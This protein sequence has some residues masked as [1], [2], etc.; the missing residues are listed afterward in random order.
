MLAAPRRFG[1]SMATRFHLG[2][3]SVWRLSVAALLVLCIGLPLFVP[4]I[5]WW[6]VGGG[7]DVWS[8]HARIA[9]LA[10]NTL[11]LVGGTLL[12]T[13][14]AGI[15]C[16][17][18]LFRTDL[19]LRELWRFITVLALFVPLPLLASGWQAALGSGGWLPA[20]SWSTPSPGD[21]DEPP[22]GPGW[23]PWAQGLGA[24][25]WVHS[26]AALPW[27][28]LIVGQGLRWV[29][30]ELEEDALL[31]F[32]PWR[33]LWSVT[34]VRARGAVLAA[35]AWGALQTAGEIAVTDMMQVRTFAEEI[36]YQFVLGDSAAL[37]RAVT[38][39]IPLLVV[40]TMVVF[41]LTFRLERGLP[42]L[43]GLGDTDRTGGLRIALGGAR[44]PALAAVLVMVGLLAGLPLI[45]LVWK[46]GL[47]GSP[48]TF[49]ANVAARQVIEVFQT[50]GPLIG[51]SLLVAAGAGIVTA[52]LVLVACWL[53]VESRGLLLLLLGLTALA[54]ALPAPLI[55]LGLKELIGYVLDAEDY[56]GGGHV[57]F[58]RQ[59]LYD[60]PSVLPV[61]WVAVIRFLPCA[62][63]LLWP[64]V[65]L[66][67]RELRDLA[68]LDGLTPTEEFLLVVRPILFPAF[69]RTV[70]AVA[71]L[72]L[73]EISAGKFVET[74]GAPTFAHEVFNQMHYGVKEKLAALCLVL[75]LMV[76]AAASLLALAMK[77]KRDVV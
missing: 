48:E 29:E 32:G 8:E 49:S 43:T 1:D 39:N 17:F 69:L 63:V 60:G 71:I 58:G 20:A 59:L 2:V 40:V 47:S 56:L 25:T 42:P 26:L 76:T 64:I 13:L 72:T 38:V 27:V 36:Y 65:R 50:K 15:A 34:L 68:R 6:R 61:L 28:I 16:A 74:P 12:L 45:S 51:R 11:L 37:A 67:P 44:W 35:A 55:G 54:W 24:A 57:R 5:D 19:P 75:L 31:V 10:G 46:A 41:A 4:F 9:L 62:V 22:V 21:P 77:W 52:A 33:V 70:L 3:T 7:G 18:L 14:P 23:K 66:F 53:A 30:P 73:G